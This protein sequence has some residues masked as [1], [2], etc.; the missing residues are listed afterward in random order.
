MKILQVIPVF[1]SLFG[2]AVNVVCS[3]SK[4]L[5]KKHDVTV[6]TTTAKDNKSDFKDYPVKNE[7]YGYQVFYFP[8]IFRSSQFNISPTMARALSETISEYDIIHLHSWRQFQDLVVHHY[9]MKYNVPYVLQVH[10]SLPRIMMKQRSKWFYDVLFG[11]R[12]LRDASEVIAL[13][14]NEFQQYKA[15]GVPEEEIR[16]IPN[17]LDLEEYSHLP[18]QGYFRK[19]FS[20]EE[21]E[22]IVLY[23]GRINETKG[24]G[25]LTEA[26]S[27]VT[28]YL[29]NV[30]LLFVGPDDG[31]GGRLSELISQLGIEDRVL[32]TGF[33]EK[34]EKLGALL[35]SNVLV[36]P[37]FYGF[38]VTFLEAC[39]T[40]CPIVTSVDSLEW[41]HNNVGYV[42][43][44]SP[45]GVSK[46]ILKILLDNSTSE[47]FKDN[48]TKTIK[49]FEI[50]IV[51]DKLEK[52][53]RISAW[54]CT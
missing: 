41:I 16:I 10:G 4:E 23:L 43:E 12:V 8:R 17:G 48:C 37:R 27:I 33:V 25:L 51:A 20:I 45:A 29:K 47:K 24:L 21:E 54:G 40:R 9:A 14:R 2:G 39:F 18:P 38:P 11:Y 50:S 5:A 6:Y 3:I 15:M 35:D 1:N 26:F 7:A 44:S 53:Y 46:A 28:K 13:N 42:T 30:R 19:K 32:M 22:K 34:K 49:D 36:T 31:Y 52:A